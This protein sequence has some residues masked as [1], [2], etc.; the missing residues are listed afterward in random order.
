MAVD[1]R[2]M[3]KNLKNRIHDSLVPHPQKNGGD[4]GKSISFGNLLD[5]AIM[6]LV[7]PSTFAPLI[8]SRAK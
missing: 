5:R 4:V 1:D 8:L 2:V 6:G 7:F 3:Q